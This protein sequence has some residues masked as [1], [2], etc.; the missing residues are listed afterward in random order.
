MIITLATTAMLKQE[1]RATSQPASQPASKQ[2][3]EENTNL[4]YHLQ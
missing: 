4:T 3:A 2:V 1:R